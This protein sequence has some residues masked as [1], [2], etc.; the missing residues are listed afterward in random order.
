VNDIETHVLQLIGENTASPDVFSDITPIRRSVNNGIQELCMVTGSYQQTYYLPLYTGRQFYRMGWNYDH[1]GYVVECWDRNRKLKLERTDLLSLAMRDPWLLKRSGFPYFY[2]EVGDNVIGFDRSTSGTGHLLEL[3]CVVIPKA[4][5]T[6]SKPTKV[7][8]QF[9]RGATYFAVADYYASR[10]DAQ[11]ATQYM[12]QYLEVSGL[13]K[14]HPDTADRIVTMKK[15][16]GIWDRST[17]RSP[18]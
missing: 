11:R 13:M 16:Y 6:D 15:E 3:S 1:F 7:R 5:D 2:F 10:G 4:V 17:N 18:L 9:S 8:S 12:T 14:L